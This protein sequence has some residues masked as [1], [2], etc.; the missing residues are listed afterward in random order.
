LLKIVVSVRE[1]MYKNK[2]LLIAGFGYTARHVA[3]RLS[4]REWRVLGTSRQVE[5]EQLQGMVTLIPFTALGH[6]LQECSHLLLTAPPHHTAV[7]PVLE[8]YQA[9]IQQAPALQWIGYMSTSGVY[10]D[11]QGA[12]V[13]ETTLV[14]PDI[15]RSQRR[16]EAEQAWLQL[17]TSCQLNATVFRVA[18]IYGP[19]RNMLEQLRSGHAQAI[20]K[21]QHV[22]SRIYIDDLAAAIIAALLHSEGREIFNVADDEPTASYDVLRYVAELAQLPLPEPVAYGEASLSPLARSFYS[23]CRRVD[24]SKLKQQLGVC[25]QYPTYREGYQ[26]LFC[27]SG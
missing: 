21:P 25:L 20:L 5:R 7:D 12:W 4:S 13:N 8:Q 6:Y 9:A 18:G 10:G 24:N 16:F 26:A 11:A 15:E 3:K 2:T 14:Q 17:A 22:M 27:S 1:H 23:G 19:A